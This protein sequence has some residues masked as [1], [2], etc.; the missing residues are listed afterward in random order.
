MTIQHYCAT[1]RDAKREGTSFGHTP[2]CD[3]KARPQLFY[4]SLLVLM[5]FF[6]QGCS[7]FGGNNDNGFQ[8]VSAGQNGTQLA[9]NQTAIFKGKIYFTLDHNLFMLDGNSTLHQL[10]HGMDVR[11][12]AVSPDGKWIAF[13]V[14]YKDYSD[15]VYMPVNGGDLHTVVTGKGQY[16][17]NADG[18]N[19]FFWFAQPAWSA[20]STQ[21]LFL[22]DLQKLYYWRSLGG[23]FANAFFL[24]MQVFSLPINS[25]AL[26]G[27]QA[28]NSAQIVAYADFGDGGDRDPSY[29]PQHPGQVIY[30][31][32]TYDATQT[33]QVIQIFL[34]DTTLMN[35]TAGYHPGIAGSGY[36]PAIP[37]TPPTP[38]IRNIQPTFSPNGNYM[39]YI[40]SDAAGN[41]GLYVAPVANGVTQTPNDPATQQKALAPYQQ[42]ALIVQQQYVG[43]PE[44]SPDGSEIAF[45]GYTN[46]TFD[47]WLA[48]VKQNTKT[49]VYSMTDSP[50]QL[51]NAGGHLDADS[52]PF[53][54]P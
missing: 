48:S 41:M 24:D 49:G 53:W 14:H 13:I 52:R 18:Y 19:D 42:A 36:D 21:L 47:L 33:K 40:H 7:W 5:V 25:P 27:A 11:D 26:T 35:T 6:L 50:I 38:D 8:G 16:Y 10:T 9:V 31:H 34:E 32:Y 44:W 1:R 12:P 46:S 51:T 4:L 54:T 43:Q 30:T 37:L 3:R 17:P 29:R 2:V 20:D 22:S 39:A 23:V 28:L 15:L 45:M